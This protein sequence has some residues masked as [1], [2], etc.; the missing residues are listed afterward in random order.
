[1][2]A[3]IQTTQ[4][5]NAAQPAPATAGPEKINADI[6][7]ARAAN[8]DRR[9]GDAEALMLPITGSQPS[10]VLPWIELG[11]AQLGLKKYDGAESSFKS[12]LG[13]RDNGQKLEQH[14]AGFYANSG[15]KNAV[16]PEATRASSAGAGGTISNG[17]TR[18]PEIMGIAYSDLGQVYILTG[19]TAEAEA[20]FDEAVKA[21]PQDAPL[22]RRNEMVF[23]YQA[24][25]SEAQL[26]VANQAIAID[27]NRAMLHY[28]RGQA[29]VGQATI[30]A[31]TQKMI[32]PPGC[33][34]AYQKYL[35]LEPNGPYADDAKS[36]L[37]AAGLPLKSK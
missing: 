7:A 2:F 28:F 6:A 16:A 14:A 29:L 5:Q 27:P 23:F 9:Y 11:T 10:L 37:T 22:Y 33:A 20:S 18:T 3:A 25:N 35:A 4:A 13:I 21:N 26:K 12:A 8:K 32:L 19:K 31:K 30:D 36:I 34:E 1:M 17:S 15:D 24:G